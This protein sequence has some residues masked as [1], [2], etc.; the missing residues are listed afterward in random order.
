MV[1]QCLRKSVSNG[2]RA[3]TNIGEEAFRDSTPCEKTGGFGDR[4]TA[5][6]EVLA[7]SEDLNLVYVLRE[8]MLVRGLDMIWTGNF[9]VALNHLRSHHFGSLVFDLSVPSIEDR[10]VYH[11]LDEYDLTS[12]GNKIF[13]A[14]LST[15][16]AL[17]HRLE[18]NG[19]VV[20]PAHSTARQ[21]LR[22]VSFPPET[23]GSRQD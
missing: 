11:L 10:H 8:N 5:K 3:E 20:L 15:S 2:A 17:R 9:W 22:Y 19:H 16:M 4:P 18:D 1:T 12:F 14:A 6:G 7:L 13:I 21:V 23:S